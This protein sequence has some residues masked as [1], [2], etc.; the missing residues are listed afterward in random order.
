[1]RL[2]VSHL[3]SVPPAVGF[4]PGVFVFLHYRPPARSSIVSAASCAIIR[5]LP[6]P[7]TVAPLLFFTKYCLPIMTTWYDMPAVPSNVS[8]FI[9]LSPSAAFTVDLVEEV[10][11]FFL[12]ANFALVALVTSVPLGIRLWE[13][14]VEAC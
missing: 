8:T 12:G 2:V 5:L 4:S 1:M 6:G 3:D 13:A 11:G 7:Q 10:V 9:P 14:G